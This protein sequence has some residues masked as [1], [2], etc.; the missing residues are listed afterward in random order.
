MRHS[1]GASATIADRLV[2]VVFRSHNADI[3][4][5]EA[6]AEGRVPTG[7]GQNAARGASRHDVG[8]VHVGTGRERVARHGLL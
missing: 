5:P 1:K 8:A 7:R 2:R 3:D 6:A 4:L